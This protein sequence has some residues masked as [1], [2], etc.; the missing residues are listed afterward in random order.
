MLCIDPGL[1]S[2]LIQLRDGHMESDQLGDCLGQHVWRLLESPRTLD[3]LIVGELNALHSE[4]ER[5]AISQSQLVAIAHNILEG[6][7]ILEA[8]TVSSSTSCSTSGLTVF[9]AVEPRLQ[10]VGI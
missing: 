3:R 10:V 2:V 1:L 7:G 9:Q 6:R 5:G 8:A 4:M